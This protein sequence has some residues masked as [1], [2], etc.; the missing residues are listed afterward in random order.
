[1]L[2]TKETKRSPS[3]PLVHLRPYVAFKN[4]SH[5]EETFARS[6]RCR[7][8]GIL[9]GP[10]CSFPAPCLTALFTGSHLLTVRLLLPPCNKFVAG[11]SGYY[12]ACLIGGE[13]QPWRG[14]VTCL[15]TH[16]VS[17]GVIHLFIELSIRW[18][19]PSCTPEPHI[20]LSVGE[21]MDCGKEGGEDRGKRRGRGGKYV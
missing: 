1:M 21:Q 14:K 12:L 10:L 7:T 13:I 18:A 19:P 6:R 15:Q 8:W 20:T 5:L 9:P 16:K 2:P 3:V 11:L 4:P 17:S